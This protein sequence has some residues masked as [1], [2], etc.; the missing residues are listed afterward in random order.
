VVALSFMSP[1]RRLSKLIVK[2]IVKSLTLGVLV[3]IG[4]FEMRE[5]LGVQV[6]DSNAA[7][8]DL[9]AYNFLQ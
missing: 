3:P 5:R 4:E 7:L 9:S 2:G 8:T 1:T 6:N